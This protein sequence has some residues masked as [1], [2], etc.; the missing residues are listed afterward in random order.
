MLKTLS[1]TFLIALLLLSSFTLLWNSPVKGTIYPSNA[2]LKA[3]LFSLR[4]TFNAPVE[5]GIFQ[6]N[7]VK[8][9]SYTLMVEG[10]PPYRNAVKN[11]V[12][13]VDGQMTDVGVIEMQP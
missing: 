10:R 2:G 13:V 1:L 9:G 5:E 7:N 6:I 8:P 3:W 11:T 4:D 12:I